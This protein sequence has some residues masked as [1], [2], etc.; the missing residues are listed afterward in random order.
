MNGGKSGS[1]QTERLKKNLPGSRSPTEANYEVGYAKPPVA[2]RFQPGASGNPRGRP[3]GAKNKRPALGEERL[4]DIILD[5]AYRDITVRDGDTNMTVPMAQAVM[6]SIAVN[7]AKGQYRA[8]H[9]FSTLLMETEKSRKALSDE[10]VETALTYKIEWD[11]ELYRRE[12][13]GITHLREPFPHP[14]HVKLDMDTGQVVITG[15]V[16]EKQRDQLEKLR[17]A[18]TDW[19]EERDWLQTE[20]ARQS[21]EHEDLTSKQIAELPEVKML[22][23]DLMHSTSLIERADELLERWG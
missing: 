14:R 11:R 15:P 5:E 23:E 22:I 13:L 21:K 3:K 20:I 9:L 7:A 18:R 6:R 10:W 17:T 19:I 12:Q 1:D 4:K 2:T 16:T 8:Q